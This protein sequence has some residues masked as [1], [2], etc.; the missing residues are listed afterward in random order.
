MRRYSSI[1]IISLVALSLLLAGSPA[2][3]KKKGIKGRYLEVESGI[4]LAG[5]K[6]ALIVLIPAEITADKDRAVDIESV[7]ATSDD[8][9]RETLQSSGL[10]GSIVTEPPIDLPEGQP[11]L[12]I[13]TKL[14]L[15]FGSQAMRFWVGGGAG[16]SKLHIRI[17]I[18]DAR[19]GAHLAF[20]NGYGTGAGW[21]S[22]SGGGVQRMARD[23]FQE[24][25]LKLGE[26]LK[27]KMK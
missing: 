9:L 16:K 13:T 1:T 19:T 12:K 11:I 25:Y 18:V 23:D 4:D 14:T 3:A 24:N 27:E 7:R 8:M 26:T 10:F 21:W 15:Q 5:Y 20:F 2:E 17:D 22:V 6:G